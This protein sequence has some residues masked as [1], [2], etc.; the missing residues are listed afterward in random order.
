M[1]QPTEPSVRARIGPRFV[2]MVI[3]GLLTFALMVLMMVL[4]VPY[5]VQGAGPTFNTLQ[6]HEQDDGAEGSDDGEDA[7]PAGDEDAV[8]AL[9]SVSGA[10]SYPA[11]GELRLTT[12]VTAGGPGFAVR[13]PDVVSGFWSPSQRVQPV[14]AVYEPG[15]TRQER[16]QRSAQQ[17]VTSQEHAT[18]AALTE[19]GYD[20]PAVMHIVGAAPDSGAEGVVAEDDLILGIDV[21]GSERVEVQ[22]YQDLADP[23]AQTDPGTQVELWVERDGEEIALPIVTT[24]DGTGRTQLGIFLQ[25]EFDMPV[26]VS[27]AIDNVGG[28]SAGVMFALGVV[29]VL[30]EGD[31]TGGSHIAGTGTITMD[32]RIGPIGGV[33]LKMIGALRDGASHFLAPTFNCGEVIGNEPG[34]LQVVAVSNLSQARDAVEAIAV[35]DDA[36]LP[37]CRDHPDAP[38]G[39]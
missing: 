39:N 25:A 6:G 21:T 12:V 9:I 27:I 8:P 17:M 7:D 2:V 30:T 1:D 4:P 23:L 18:V 35:G 16:D 29:D 28:P 32:G 24:D 3:S 36:D 34:G 22:T 15:L 11:D 33:Q 10:E 38:G 13:T 20:V 31:L 19:L 5:A 14:E 37:T 26:D